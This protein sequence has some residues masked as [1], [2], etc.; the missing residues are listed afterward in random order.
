MEAGP[1]E[2]SYKITTEQAGNLANLQKIAD[3]Q[4]LQECLQHFNAMY[5]SWKSAVERNLTN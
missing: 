4:F 2:Q 5:L 3:S 1:M